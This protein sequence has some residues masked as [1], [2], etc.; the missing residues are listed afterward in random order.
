MR[1]EEVYALK[2]ENDNL[3]NGHGLFQDNSAN[4]LEGLRNI[5]NLTV[6]IV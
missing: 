6:L 3:G 2:S 4:H 1:R 5:T